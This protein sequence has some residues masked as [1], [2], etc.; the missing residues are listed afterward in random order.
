MLEHAE[1]Y[2]FEH[3]NYTSK[4]NL[5]YDLMLQLYLSLILIENNSGLW[6]LTSK[7]EVIYVIYQGSTLALQIT[8]IYVK[9]KQASK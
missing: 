5:S 6:M 1:V 2:L 3:K 4:F 9:N 8:S 7:L